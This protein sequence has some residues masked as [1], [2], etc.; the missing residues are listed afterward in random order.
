MNK[1]R[2]VIA[3][4]LCFVLIVS[5]AVTAYAIDMTAN[6]NA[7]FRDQPDDQATLI[8]FIFAGEILR[9]QHAT[10]NGAWYYGYPD[11]TAT[12]YILFGARK[13]YS[14]SSYYSVTQY[15]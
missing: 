14:R 3:F 13:A 6:T 8:G 7:P 12:L 9:V 15:S 1:T 10:D 5:L 4:I 11:P 2:K